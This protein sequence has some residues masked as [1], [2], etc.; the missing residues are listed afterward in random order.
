MKSRLN[1][2]N[3]GVAEYDDNCDFNKQ[4]IGTWGI[5]P[6]GNIYANLDVALSPATGWTS[7]SLGFPKSEILA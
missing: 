5:T 2:K 4:I 1:L 7:W 6:D 3:D